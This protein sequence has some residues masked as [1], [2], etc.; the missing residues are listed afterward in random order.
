VAQATGDCKPTSLRLR[1]KMRPTRQNG[2]M[3]QPAANLR[4]EHTRSTLVQLGYRTAARDRRASVFESSNEHRGALR[5]TPGSVCP[6]PEPNATELPSCAPISARAAQRRRGGGGV[7]R[8]ARAAR[9]TA[10]APK[11]KSCATSCGTSS[12]TSCAASFTCSPFTCRP[13]LPLGLPHQQ[14]ASNVQR[15]R[16]DEETV[17]EET[18]GGVGVGGS[19]KK[20]ARR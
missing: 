9:V 17:D 18:L 14:R 15:A 8:R 7:A 10:R 2:R 19:W 6:Q 13:P 12:A 1:S 3:T 20:S 5:G 16:G 4:A 11:A